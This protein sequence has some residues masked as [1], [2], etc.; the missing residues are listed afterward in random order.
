MDVLGLLVATLTLAGR[1]LCTLDVQ[2]LMKPLLVQNLTL[3]VS[4]SSF[5]AACCFSNLVLSWE[6]IW[7]IGG[8]GE[9]GRQNFA[10]KKEDTDLKV[11]KYNK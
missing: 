7:N 9:V 1:Q 4:S 5:V 8:E 11:Q 3:T 6:Q 10:F 2:L